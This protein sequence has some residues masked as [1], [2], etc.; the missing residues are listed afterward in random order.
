MSKPTKIIL[1][2]QSDLILN[3]ARIVGATGIVKSDLPGLVSD[4]AS[5]DTAIQTE[6]TDRS[7]AIQAEAGARAAEI[8]SERA[9]IDAIL[10][11]SDVNLDQFREVVAFVQSIDLANDTDLLAKVTEINLKITAEETARIAADAAL[12]ADLATLQSYVDTTVN[13]AIA[14]LSADLQQESM[15]RSQ[16]DSQLSQQ[17]S[18]EAAQR[19]QAVSQLSQQLSQESTER[20][21]DVDA[22]ETRALAA[23]AALQAALDAETAARIADVDTIDGKI[24][25]IIANTDLTSI[26]SFA[27][28]VSNVSSEISARIAADNSLALVY[29]NTYS[30]HVNV[31]ETPNGVIVE[32]NLHKSI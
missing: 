31:I 30:K 14:Q 27:E 12:T 3:N 17:I 32:F 20:I 1:D 19:S 13:D 18:D 26:D 25:D 5:L 11:G 15:Q 9:R 16:V 8:A 4:L 6:A 2:K 22:E 23:E 24:A 7:A 28:V 21:A 10:D 29:N